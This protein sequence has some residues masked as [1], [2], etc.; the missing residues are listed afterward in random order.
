[1]AVTISVISSLVIYPSPLM[2]YKENVHRNFS[3]NDPRDNI[4]RPCTNS[5]QIGKKKMVLTSP[6]IYKFRLNPF[7][8]ITSKLTIP[9]LS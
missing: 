9:L 3:S 5:C 6:F 2:S 7:N 1:M 4:D 8:L